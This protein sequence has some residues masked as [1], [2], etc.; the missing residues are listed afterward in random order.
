MGNGRI[1]RDKAVNDVGGNRRFISG[2]YFGGFKGDVTFIGDAVGIFGRIIAKPGYFF[3]RDEHGDISACFFHAIKPI[4]TLRTIGV[5]TG[6]TRLSNHRLAFLGF[7]GTDA[8][9]LIFTP[10]AAGI[11]AE[12]AAVVA[13]NAARRPGFKGI[14]IFV[15]GAVNGLRD[16][17]TA[18]SSSCHGILFCFVVFCRLVG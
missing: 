7:S 10:A 4:D 17:T 6:V 18:G 11:G 13:G 1:S 12:A 15:T 9:G 8:Q 3:F 2:G 14:G 16:C 5:K